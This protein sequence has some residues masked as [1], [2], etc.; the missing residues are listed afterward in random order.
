MSIEQAKAFLQELAGNEELTQKLRSCSSADE[1]MKLAKEAGFEF[2]A[3]EFSA[4]R[5]GLF[6]EELNAVSGGN[7]CGSTSECTD[8]GHCGYTCE[9]E[10]KWCGYSG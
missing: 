4:A 6:D 5:S 10:A 7:C 9:K 8:D 2:T 1:R 3:E